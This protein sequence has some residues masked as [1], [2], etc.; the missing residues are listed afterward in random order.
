MFFSIKKVLRSLSLRYGADFRRYR[1]VWELQI[2]DDK[3]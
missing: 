3:T 1:I 2:A